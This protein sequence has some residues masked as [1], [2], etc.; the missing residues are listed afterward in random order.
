MKKAFFILASMICI[1]H[2]E[3]AFA[4]PGGLIAKAVEKTLLGKIVLCLLVFVLFPIIVWV[5][6]TEHLATKRATKDLRY[7]AQYSHLFEWL[8]IR[9]RAKD[10]FFRVHSSWEDEDLTKAAVWMTDW[11]WQNQQLTC[12][13]RWKKEGLQNI[14]VVN[15]INSIR[16]ILFVHKNV[17]GTH[18]ESMVVISISAT[19]QDFLQDRETGEVVE[20]DQ[21]VKDVTRVWSFTLIGGQWKVSDISEGSS[22]LDFAKLRHTLPAIETTLEPGL[23]A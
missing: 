2:A 6:I 9:E 5:M 14:C 12:L 20:G 19:M 23:T 7:M 13:E 3:P 8:K 17:G 22:S 11:Y 1:L 16:P 21:I 15:K 10:C 4:G 18:E